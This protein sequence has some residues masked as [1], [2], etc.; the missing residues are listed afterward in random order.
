MPLGPNNTRTFYRKLYAGELETVTV[1]KRGDDQQQG[2]VRSV[3]VFNARH[4]PYV[5]TGETIGGEESS[6]FATTWHFPQI[7]LDR[8]G[9]NYLN[10]LD[11]IIDKKGRYWQPEASLQLTRKLFENH[12]CVDCLSVNPPPTTTPP[13]IGH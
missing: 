12:Y 8:V 5:K 11:R 3:K 9:I 10:N 2:T 13:P 7:E 6:N 1:L 4:T